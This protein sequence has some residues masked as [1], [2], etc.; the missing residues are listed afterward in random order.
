MLKE[1]DVPIEG[2][3]ETHFEDIQML[4]DARPGVTIVKFYVKS[5]E[6]PAKSREAGRIVRENFIWIQKIMNL[7]NAILHRRVRDKIEWDDV[8]KKWKVKML[9]QGKESDVRRYTNEWNAFARGAN[10]NSIGT[11]LQFLFKNDPARV[12]AYKAKYITTIEQLAN[13]SASHL[14]E[15]G[16]GGEEDKK[17]AIYYL[18]KIEKQVPNLEI[19]NKLEEKD[20]QIETLMNRVNDLTAKLTEVLEAQLKGEEKKV[21]KTKP[22]KAK[23]SYEDVSGIEG[24]E[25]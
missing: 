13:L 21:K 4:D 1:I 3:E 25:G 14:K 8:A 22:T 16:I 12:D 20:R 6:M 19:N 17:H 5:E 18:D 23:E 7:G 24:F 15:I 2:L 11:P 9:A 10:E